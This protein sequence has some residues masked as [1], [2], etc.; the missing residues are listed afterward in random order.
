MRITTVT[1][2]AAAIARKNE[3]NRQLEEL[4]ATVFDIPE[5]HPL[6]VELDQI[7]EAIDRYLDAEVYASLYPCNF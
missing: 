4:Y 3:I 6:E 1:E 7:S 2:Y 5:D